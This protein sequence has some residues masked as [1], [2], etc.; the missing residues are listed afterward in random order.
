MK[1]YSK[2]FDLF[3]YQSIFVPFFGIL[4]YILEDPFH[5]K[6]FSFAIVSAI[7]ATVMGITGVIMNLFVREPKEF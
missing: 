1:Y 4:L 3:L 6:L 7:I 2:I 5:A